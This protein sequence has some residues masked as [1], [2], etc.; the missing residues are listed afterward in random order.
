MSRTSSKRKSSTGITRE[1]YVEKMKQRKNENS[2]NSR[3][4]N[5]KK[6]NNKKSS[7]RKKK[8]IK[9]ILILI[10]LAII[11]IL[12]NTIISMVSFWQMAKDMIQNMPSVIVDSSGEEI[13]QVGN[14]RNRENISI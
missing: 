13:T 5:S 7:S 12:V 2:S 10:L 11:I 3:S 8:I 1:E 14:E 9:I 6:K 4:K